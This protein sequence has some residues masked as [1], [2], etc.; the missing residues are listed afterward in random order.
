[1]TRIF[2]FHYLD[3]AVKNN[4]FKEVDTSP[5][6]L[7]VDTLLRAQ[8]SLNYAYANGWECEG[9]GFVAI[10][11]HG[12]AVVIRSI[13]RGYRGLSPKD[14]L[15]NILNEQFR[16]HKIKVDSL[17]T[18]L[19]VLHTYP[20]FKKAMGEA[21]PQPLESSNWIVLTIGIWGNGAKTNLNA[22][23]GRKPV[24]F[25]DETLP[26]YDSNRPSKSIIRYLEFQE[27]KYGKTSFRHINFDW[28]DLDRRA[29]VWAMHKRIGRVFFANL[30]NK[31]QGI[32]EYFNSQETAKL[33]N[34]SKFYKVTTTPELM[35][36]EGF[37]DGKGNIL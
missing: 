33:H 19:I 32:S 27:Q 5:P 18:F 20:D 28:I 1:M 34:V 29:V 21:I 16:T 12:T 37:K 17:R 31:A 3:K 35:V 26:W 15:Q 7:V 9:L 23:Y 22:M 25:K 10:R 2:G 30:Y 14:N 6:K 4:R 13:R 24:P 8:Q 11:A 36:F